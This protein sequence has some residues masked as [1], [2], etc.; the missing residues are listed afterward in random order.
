[1][2]CR[3]E[4]EDEAAKA[5]ATVLL[6]R[7]GGGALGVRRRLFEELRLL[8]MEWVSWALSRPEEERE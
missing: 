2:G 5:P 7:T 4:G 3:G 8:W 6:G 1:M